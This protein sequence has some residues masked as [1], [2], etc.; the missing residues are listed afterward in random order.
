[1]QRKLISL[2]RDA[3]LWEAGDAAR[4]IALVDK[5][6][7]GARTDKGLVG[8]A[9]PGMVLGESALLTLDGEPDR[10]SA[11]VFALEEDTVV[12]AVPASEVRYAFENGEDAVMPRVLTNLVGQI[13]R[14]LLMVVSAKRGYF[15]VD[16]PLRSLVQGI[17][18]D[19]R[20]A[21]ALRSW[22]DMLL[23]CRFLCDLRDLSD[24]LLSQ[25]GPDPAQRGDMLASAA[26]ALAQLAEG[27]ELRPTLELFLDAERQKS[28]WWSRGGA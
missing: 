12:T 7:L 15:Y 26:G 17:L 16:E 11:A 27:Q 6:R 4:D 10:R 23:T 21:P 24:R 8:I 5:G 3:V 13:T 22:H 20:Q 9:L 25:L 19:A 28:D 14:N 2:S 18:R 1:M